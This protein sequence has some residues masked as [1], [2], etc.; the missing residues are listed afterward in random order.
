MSPSHS[1]SH[2]RYRVSCRN[3]DEF[4]AFEQLS[5]QAPRPPPAARL[6]VPELQP[7]EEAEL[8]AQPHEEQLAEL[9]EHLAALLEVVA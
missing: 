7:E 8:V 6:V 9:Q 2:G 1:Y 5:E 4:K 3:P